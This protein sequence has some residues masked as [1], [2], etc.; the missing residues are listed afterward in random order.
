MRDGISIV[1]ISIVLFALVYAFAGFRHTGV[2]L[3]VAGAATAKQEAVGNRNI[4]KSIE[5]IGNRQYKDKTLR[6]RLDFEKGD[7]LDLFVAEAG[8]RTIAEVYRTIGYAFVRVTVDSEKLSEG[9]VVYTIEEGARV[10]IGSVGFRGN[11][12]IKTGTLK[13]VIKTKEKKWFHW[14]HYYTKEQIAKDV[15]RLEDFYYERGFLDY[16]I[17]AKTKLTDDNSEVGVTYLIDEGPAYRIK[18][19]LFTDNKHFTDKTLRAEL[20]LEPGQVYRKREAD[21]DAKRLLKLYREHGFIDVAIEQG[22]RF[23]PRTGTDVVNVEFKITEGKQFRIGRIDITGNE[24]TQDRVVRRVLDEYG[25]TPGQ[26]YNGDMA[27]KQGHGKLEKYVQRMV[28]AEEVIIRPVTPSSGAPEQR[29]ARVDIKEGMTGFINPGIGVSSDYGVIG[30]LIYEQR[31]FDI[32]DWPESLHELITM[33]AFRGAGQRL[34]IAL[35]PGTEVSVYA[36]NFSEPYFRDKPTRLDVA[37]SSYERYRESYDEGRLKS[38]LGF[39]Q[40]LENMWRKSIGFRVENVDV[41]SLDFDAPQKIIDVKGNNLLAGV[42]FGVGRNAIDD[43]YNPSRGYT[44]NT[45]YEQVTGDDTFGKLEGTY[46]RHKTLYEDVLERKTVLTVKLRAGT[47]VIHDAPP[48]EK[49]YAG[50][51]GMYGI[52]GF[53]YRGVSTR[54]LQTNVANPERKD[55]IGSDWVFLANT[56][57]IV[58]LIGENFDA[59]F[60]I[61]SGAIDTGP[62]RSSI[63][64][65]IQIRIP[66]WFGAPVPMRFE[67]AVPLKKDDN[68]ETQ[69]FSFSMGRL[70]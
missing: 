15:E 43:I 59:M 16:S 17:T 68:D 45:S 9:N 57:L 2:G 56:E 19:I 33:R 27:P 50:G 47:T 3:A 31:N 58:P 25:F 48:F 70:F 39:E 21:S 24:L 20:E 53:E 42:K 29:D 7:Y 52:R 49:F 63:G 51:T 13:K 55:P 64:A 36:I 23:I 44:F 32:K 38:Y 41:Q 61:D 26:L 40:R 14:P 8:R 54:G 65:G 37:G 28:V 69:A 34:R 46:V 18:E 1:F 6:Q 67:V 35:E 22:A 5:F 60:F 10:K 62:Y 66:H 4:V 11:K 30:Q 12:A